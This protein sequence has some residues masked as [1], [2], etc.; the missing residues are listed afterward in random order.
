M[1]YNEQNQQMEMTPT[2]N[3]KPRQSRRNASIQVTRSHTRQRNI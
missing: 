1:I 2:E 3:R